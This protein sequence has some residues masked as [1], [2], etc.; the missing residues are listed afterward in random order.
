MIGKDF[1]RQV[2]RYLQEKGFTITSSA[3]EQL[4]MR[5]DAVLTE[6][7]KASKEKGKTLIDKIE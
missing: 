3:L 1:E 2:R 4:M 5:I 6:V 7:M